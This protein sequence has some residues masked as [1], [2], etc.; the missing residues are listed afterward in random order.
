METVPTE[1]IITNP[2]TSVRT[3]AENSNLTSVSPT[4]IRQ[5]IRISS[6]H[7][8]ELNDQ[9]GPST[10]PRVNIDP[11][12]PR[13]NLD[14]VLPQRNPSIQLRDVN[15]NNRINNPAN[16]S[17]DDDDDDDDDDSNEEIERQPNVELHVTSRD[18]LE[19]L[20]TIYAARAEERAEDNRQNSDPNDSET[21]R[22]QPTTFI[23]Q[24]RSHSARTVLVISPRSTQ[25]TVQDIP[26]NHKIHTNSRRLL[27]YLEEPNVGQGFIKEQSWSPDGRIICSPFAFGLRLLSF[28]DQ[29]SELSTC[30]RSKP[31][32]LYELVNNLCHKNTVV[33]TRFSP[34]HTMLVSG[35]LSGKI[36][37]HQPIL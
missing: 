27:N 17:D 22:S 4:Q 12:L 7:L 10:L 25:R 3:S 37:F 1:D 13:V 18:V 5:R 2:S 16:D 26:K 30:D 19:A 35:C 29:C 21:D 34:T 15:P 8:S 11:V 31:R 14:H 6:T 20:Q 9:P 24:T 32:P 33:S 36:V 28:N 23:I